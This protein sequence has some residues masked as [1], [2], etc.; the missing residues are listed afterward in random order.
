MVSSPEMSRSNSVDD[1]QSLHSPQPPPPAT[2]ILTAAAHLDTVDSAKNVP[3]AGIH[4]S[5]STS[6]HNNGQQSNPHYSSN[7]LEQSSTVKATKNC[8]DSKTTPTGYTSFS[9][10]SIL[11]R[12]EPKKEHLIYP[13]VPLLPHHTPEDLHNSAIISR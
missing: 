11:S 1:R 4:K 12:N 7:G 8:L 6:G 10:S 5:N 2:Q 13:S 9:I 3:F